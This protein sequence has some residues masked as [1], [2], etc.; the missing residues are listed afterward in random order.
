MSETSPAI[1]KSKLPC[2]RNGKIRKKRAKRLKKLKL[3][4]ANVDSWESL[5]G[6]Q[7]ASM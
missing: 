5:I 4:M 3:A 7:L 6:W 1:N 2:N